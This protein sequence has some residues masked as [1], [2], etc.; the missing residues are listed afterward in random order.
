M[1][2]LLTC[3]AP[4][5]HWDPKVPVR[6]AC[7]KRA[8]SV[9]PEP[10][11]NSPLEFKQ[12]FG[13]TLLRLSGIRVDQFPYAGTWRTRCLP[14]AFPLP[15]CHGAPCSSTPQH[16]GCQTSRRPKAAFM[17]SEPVSPGSSRQLL[18][19][20]RPPFQR[21]LQSISADPPRQP[22]ARCLFSDFL[23]GEACANYLKINHLRYFGKWLNRLFRTAGP[24]PAPFAG[25]P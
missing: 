5:R 15:A 21:A 19:P 20:H 9:R 11:S 2:R 12:L 13:Q 6:L 10:G 23:R 14:G 17:A 18:R 25:Q 8:A 22:L 3:Y 16:P 24:P 4:V 1:G 7:V